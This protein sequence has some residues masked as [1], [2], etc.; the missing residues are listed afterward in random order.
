M[1]VKLGN[2]FEMSS[3]EMSSREMTSEEGKTVDNGKI[4]RLF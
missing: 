2:G 3:P 4:L 1:G